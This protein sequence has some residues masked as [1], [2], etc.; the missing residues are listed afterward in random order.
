MSRFAILCFTERGQRLGERIAAGIGGA[1]VRP[2]KGA[3]MP[4]TARLFHEVD[5]LVFIG[6][7]GIAVRAIAPLVRDKTADPA[8]IVL[9]E[10]GSNVISLLSG[11]IGGAN[12][13]A[14]QIAELTGGRAV[15]TT[16]TDVNGRF[17]AD[18]WASDNHCVIDSPATAKAYAAAILTRD[19][20]LASD[21]PIRG[22]LPEGVFSAEEGALGAAITVR[23]DDGPF[24]TTLRLIPRILHVGV[25]CKRGA[26]TGKI[27]EAIDRA[28]ASGGLDPR[29]VR[30]VATIDIKKDEEGLLTYCS[31]RD[32][33]VSCYTAQ[34]LRAVPGDF[35]H[36]DFVSQT[37]GVDNVCERAAMLSAGG[38][39]ELIVKKTALDG[40]TAAVARQKWSVS[41][42]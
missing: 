4:V 5:A 32:L 39:A 35:S 40:V 14:G 30:A 15:I 11:H 31:E 26:D 25:G 33:P 16:A 34:A 24:S 7:C 18:A 38:G 6:A 2:E 42:E 10:K 9:D 19:L 20:P 1:V 27:A 8:V 29:A 21:F 3:L 36:S 23:R 28:L 17:S 13:L 22:G 37:V 41:F 12:A